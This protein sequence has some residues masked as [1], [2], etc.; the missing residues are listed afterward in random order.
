MSSH[1]GNWLRTP[2]PQSRPRK[3]S[4]TSSKPF[5]VEE[6]VAIARR[7]LHKIRRALETHKADQ[8][9]APM[10]RRTVGRSPV[11]IELYG[12]R[13]L[14]PT[15]STVLIIGE[16]GTGRT[17]REVYPSTQ[18]YHQGFCCHKLGAYE[19]CW[20]RTIRSR[21]GFH[22]GRQRSKGALGRG[23]GR[24]TVLDE[25]G[26]MAP[27]CGSNTRTLHKGRLD[28]WVNSH[29]RSRRSSRCCYQRIRA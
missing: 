18:H 12:D 4:G 23:R 11:M 22:R 10:N 28:G 3:R 13:A 24:N 26:E 16:S 20:K 27:A 5:K 15:R 17:C 2:T 14:C 21:A 19:T 29:D 1:S 8:L 6:V 25:V 9:S 7:A